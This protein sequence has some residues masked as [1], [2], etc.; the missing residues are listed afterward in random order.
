M[1]A[2]VVAAEGKRSRRGLSGRAFL[3][4]TL[5]Q[6]TK[7]PSSLLID[8][9]ISALLIVLSRHGLVDEING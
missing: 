8:L 5:G 9:V 4:P 1:A 2:A 7:P 6:T 3:D